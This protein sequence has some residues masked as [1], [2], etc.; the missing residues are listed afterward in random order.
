VWLKAA[1]LGIPLI[2]IVTDLV[3]VHRSW[4][5]PSVTHCFVSTT[6]ARQ[7]AIQLGLSPGQVTV[8]GHPVHPTFARLAQQAPAKAAQRHQ[9]G[10]RAELPVVLLI[11]GGEGTGHVPAVA[12]A[13]AQRLAESGLAQLVIIAGRNQRLK[14]KLTAH[15]WP[16]PTRIC[17]FVDDMP[18]WLAATE[19]L[20]TKAGPG[21]LSEAFILGLPPLIFSHIPGQETANISY[22]QSHHAG[23]A[24]SQPPAIAQQVHH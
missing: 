23:L 1:G 21:T 8:A 5:C 14:D 18:Q 17:G 22:V 12:Q 10:L 24:L 13:V 7:R 3:S 9:L 15:R 20:I 16:C 6:Q 19:I 4:I 2:T 11:G